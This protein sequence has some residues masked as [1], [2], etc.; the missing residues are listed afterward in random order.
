MLPLR[1]ARALVVALLLL[2]IV[3]VVPATAGAQTKGAVD[4]AEAAQEQAYQDL[5]DANQAVGTAISELE[6]IEGEL[7]ELNY[8][9][10]R[11]ERKIVEFDT[12]VEELRASVQ[13]LV[14]EA[15]TNSGA[16]LV[17]AAFTAGSIQDLLT[18][19]S[20]IG[21]AADR[22]LASLDLLTAVNRETDRLKTE[23]AEK[24][25]RAQVLEEQQS[26]LVDRLANEQA[27]ADK[28]YEEAQHEYKD[29]YARYQEELRRKA[30][31]EARRKR[32]EAARQKAAK[33]TAAAAKSS[34]AAGLPASNTPGLVCP[35]AGNSW[36][37]DTWGAARSGGRTHK[38]VDMIAAR[39]TPL[40]A[41]NAG[42]I[43]MN[44]NALGGRQ[45]YI[46]AVDG[47]FYYYAHLS[48]YAAGLSNGQTVSKGQLLGYVGATGNATT[49]VL[50]L[51]MGPRTGVY[52]NPYPTVRR[53][54]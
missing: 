3:A 20:L 46:Y 51:G 14:V 4:K 25:A 50:H 42:R 26:V 2:G 36:F 16:G 29:A 22:D 33:N 24:Q 6:A 13:E 31:E 41:M 21:S 8:T 45:V 44:W 34:A 49:N 15:Y 47:N 9:I 28:L 54:C 23:V 48:G 12:Q 40:V 35:I 32:E 52:V 10:G 38:G 39:G 43:R 19:Q 1:Y 5:L 53:I 37:I 30:E 18:S 7:A 11:L 17:T 27:K